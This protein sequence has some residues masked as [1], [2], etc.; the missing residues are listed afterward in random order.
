MGAWGAGPF[1]NDSALDFVYEV[2]SPHVLVKAF[3]AADTGYI[4]VDDA[5]AIVVAA[6][7]V[8]ALK[9][10][11]HPDLPEDLAA[12]I[13]GFAEPDAETIALARAS[14]AAVMKDSELIELWDEGE[15]NEDSKRFHAEMTALADRLAKVVEP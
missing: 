9:G 6:E 3:A 11:P 1:E 5:S 12:Q 8:A 10:F 15:P 13:A 4:D 2:Q 14:L 7:C